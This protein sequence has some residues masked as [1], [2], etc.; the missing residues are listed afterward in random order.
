[1]RELLQR[2]RDWF[3]RNTLDQDLSEEL[4]FHRASL[5]RDAAAA[6]ADPANVSAIASRRLGNVTLAREDARERWGIP[7]VSQALRE[8]RYAIRGLRRSPGFAIAALLILTV[9]IGAN[10]AIFTIVNGVL[11]LAIPMAILLGLVWGDLSAARSVGQIAV[12][13]SGK[14][15]TAAGVQTMIGEALGDSTTAL[16]LWAPERAG[17]VD[18]D[19]AP[20]ELPR[21][22]RVH[23][24]THITNDNGPVAALIHHPTLD[25][26]SDAFHGL[27]ATSLMLVENIRL[28]DALHTSRMRIVEAGEHER[29]RLE[30]ELHDSAQNRL[31]ALQIGLSLA[32]ER[33]G[34]ASLGDLADEAGAVGE[35]LR[36]IAHG[37]SPP[38]LATQG[39]AAALT[40]QSPHSAIPVEVVAGDIGL[41]EP[42]VERAVYLCCLESIQNAAKHGGDGTSATVRLRRENGQLLFSVADDGRGF[43]PHAITPG[44]GLANL[45]ERADTAGGRVEILSAPGQ[46]TTV[47]GAV[48]W[49]ARA[50][51]EP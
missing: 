35:D 20:L 3:R 36:R 28:L 5:E 46:G 40:A 11:G 15:L 6:G 22:P 17:Y 8:A 37:L 2:I 47:T 32:Q 23:G 16:A 34:D 26:D 14:P 42:H 9:G 13:A 12:R 38:M 1:M 39:L 43:D 49:P 30:S 41:S 29:R 33:T 51:S 24:V 31:I 27:A 48:P 44:A 19:G 4:A 21:D 7:W 25:T 50:T 18:V 10:V 45:H